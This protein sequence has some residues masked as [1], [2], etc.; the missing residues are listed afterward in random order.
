MR[1][2]SNSPTRAVGAE[3]KKKQDSKDSPARV[4]LQLSRDRASIAVPVPG[5]TPSLYDGAIPR[6]ENES[7]E[8]KRG[9][10]AGASPKRKES[11]TGCGPAAKR[12]RFA[13]SRTETNADEEGQQEQ[14]YASQ[15]HAH[16]QPAVS[17]RRKSLRSSSLAAF[18]SSSLSLNP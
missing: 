11:S 17:A 10:L 14:E 2:L 6:L 12:G 1:R 16:D 18:S 13:G 15:T 7:G 3:E 5:L 8:T 9:A 4:L